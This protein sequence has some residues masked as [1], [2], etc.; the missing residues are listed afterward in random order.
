MKNLLI[1]S[2][3]FISF[4]AYAQIPKVSEGT[5]KRL[6]NFKSEYI[7]D[8]NVDIWLPNGYSK[9]KAYAVLY[10]HDGQMLFDA[11]ITWNKQEWKVDEV[12][13][14]LIKSNKI[15]ECIVVGPWNDV[16]FRH[17]DYFPQKVLEALPQNIKDTIIKNDLR[18]KAG[19]DNYLKFLVD[20]LK[21]YIDA[22]FSTKPDMKNTYVAGSSMGGLISFYAICEYPDVFHGAACI[23]THW[24][25]SLNTTDTLI[26]LAFNEYL[27]NNLPNSNTHKIYFDY[28]TETLDKNYEPFQKIIDGENHSENSWSK[29]LDIPFVFL[30]GK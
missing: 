2:A 7:E 14:A 12:I 22:N 4:S 28:G 9:D 13:S 5:I 30:M 20:E 15:E 17:R 29:R 19:S 24:P 8:R 16:N 11:N 18:G 23:S 27:K 3:L 26:P 6:V 25:G 1:I 21:P 10:M